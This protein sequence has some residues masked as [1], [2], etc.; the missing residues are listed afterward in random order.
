[1]K[2]RSKIICLLLTAILVFGLCAFGTACG[3]ETAK[4]IKGI[5]ISAP[6]T[7]TAYVQGQKFDASGMEV[8]AEYEDGTTAVVTDYAISPSGALRTV[9]TKIT[10]TYEG[11]TAEQTI[12]VAPET[13]EKLEITTAPQKTRYVDGQKFV[14]DGMVVKAIYNSGKTDENLKRYTVEPSGGLTVATKSVVIG[15]GELSVE[16]PVTVVSKTVTALTVAVGPQRT[17]YSEGETFVAEGMRVRAN[18][19]DGSSENIDNFEYSPRGRLTKND[20]L[21]DITFDGKTTAQRITVKQRYVTALTVI[22]PPVKTR[23]VEG[24]RFDD[25]GMIVK[26]EFDNGDTEEA[27]TGYSVTPAGPLPYG[28]RSVTV[29]CGNITVSQPITVIGDDRQFTAVAEEY[30][31]L[32]KF[33]HWEDETGNKVSEANPYIYTSDTEKNLTAVYS[34]F[35]ELNG[36][37]VFSDKKTYSTS[38][39]SGWYQAA[40]LTEPLKR[41]MTVEATLTRSQVANS[42]FVIGLSPLAYVADMQAHGW[43]PSDNNF[44][45]LFVP[46]YN[47]YQ[48]ANNNEAPA[49]LTPNNANVSAAVSAR[50]NY[51][52]A[53]V[54]PF[55]GVGNTVKIR[56]VL[57][58]KLLLYIDDKLFT[59]ANL[60]DNWTIGDE[61]QYYLSFAA[62]YCKSFTVTDFGFDRYVAG[63]GSFAETVS[64][65]LEKADFA[66][67]KI[68]LIGD[69]IT[70]GYGL[71]QQSERYSTRLSTGLGM[72]EN[73]LGISGTVYCTGHPT[74]QSRIEAVQ[75][76]P[77][78]TDYLLINLGVN[79]FDAAIN[80]RFAELGTF[81]GTDT[82]TVYG[83]VN[84]M[85]KAIV[86]RFRCKDVRVVITTPVITSWNNSV[87]S[88]RNWDQT[89][90]NA[91]GYSLP[92]ICKAVLDTAKHYGLIAFDLNTVCALDTSADFQDGIHP[93]AAGTRKMADCLTNFLLEN[94]SYV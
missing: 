78:D 3:G 27:F 65:P 62:N 51:D 89:K 4:T 6:P 30:K 77:Y 91:C 73:N 29:K 7:K 13:L 33:S 45:N 16:Q 20:R 54:R 2:N 61:E 81:L 10:V 26:A 64:A 83:A 35:I 74:R 71:S 17:V 85:Y 34:E 80:G 87:T 12:E 56:F 18:Y 37:N 15:Y 90:T 39:N 5:S 82:S 55:A 68:T 75:D 44:K 46:K 1:M 31:N 24:E 69:S 53:S 72:T 36:Q 42:E 58:E 40:Y 48:G 84:V 14:P 8:T 11:K 92:D 76:V 88:G 57:D 50:I 47:L 79:D 38:N 67:K 66:G 32:K 70:Y 21:I 94:Y 22:A 52:S 59:A 49:T 60:P 19:N 43:I 63:R 9:D 41:G 93:N 28:T 25:A 86:D 23:Y